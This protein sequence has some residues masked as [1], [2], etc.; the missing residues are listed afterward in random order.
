MMMICLATQTFSNITIQLDGEDV[1]ISWNGLVFPT[2][3]FQNLTGR[4]VSI[5]GSSTVTLN[6]AN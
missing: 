4:S 3:Y 5:N 6:T 2:W 1:D